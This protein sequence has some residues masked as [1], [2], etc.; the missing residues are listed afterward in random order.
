VLNWR[1]WAKQLFW[2]LFLYS[3]LF[4]D[5]CMNW[6]NWWSFSWNYISFLWLS[7][8][9]VWRIFLFLWFNAGTK[10][11]WFNDWKR[12]CYIFLWLI[13]FGLNYFLIFNFQYLLFLFDLNWR[14]WRFSRHHW[15]FSQIQ[16]EKP[17]IIILLF[18]IG[19][20][21][22][23]GRRSFLLL[24]YWGVSFLFV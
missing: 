10:T 8:L 23:N 15:R 12:F 4:I 14:Y 20:K 22:F 7:L 19:W 1:R 6:R 11:S 17:N 18:F 9:R 24:K 13:D 5:N 21:Y 3:L 16:I 2:L